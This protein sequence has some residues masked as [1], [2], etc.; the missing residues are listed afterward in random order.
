MRFLLLTDNYLPHQ[1]GSR[2]YYHQL[3]QHM[4]EEKVMVVTRKQAGDQ[5]FDD[6]QDYDIQRWPLEEAESLRKF[7]LS[8]LPI[9]KNLLTAGSRALKAFQPDLILAGELAPTGPVAAWLAWRFQ[10]PFV[11]FTHA[12]GPWTLSRTRWQSRLVRWVCRRSSAVVAASENAQQGLEEGLGIN[13]AN[14]EILLPG[15]GDVHFEEPFRATP[16]AKDKTRHTLLS[17]GRLVPRKGHDCALEAFAAVAPEYPNLQYRLLGV[18][19]EEEK[20]KA[21]A[22]QLGIADRVTFLGKCDEEELLRE[23]RGADIFLLPNRDNP[24]TGDTEGFGIVFG[25]AAAHGLP[26]IG[27]NAGGTRH[28]IEEGRTGLR[29]DGSDPQAISRALQDFL[30]SPERARLLG[31][32]GREMAMR[33]FRWADRV[34]RFLELARPLAGVR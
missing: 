1:G 34:E 12:E 31:N 5:E 15:V 4:K 11:V 29:V 10:A 32:A 24:E 7:R 20:L 9:Y 19:P 28:S 8:Q 18:G 27:G 21:K 13:P 26:C 25:E 17:V 33:R 23:Y 14:I 30:S 16:F 22:G 2:V 6:G 3:I